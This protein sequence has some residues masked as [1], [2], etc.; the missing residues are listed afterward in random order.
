MPSTRE[1]NQSDPLIGLAPGRELNIDARQLVRADSERREVL[2]DRVRKACLG[3]GFFYVDNVFAGDSVAAN[4]LSQMQ[5][6]FSLPDDD[7]RK[8]AVDNRR[9]QGSYGWMPMFG[10][11]AY[12][13]G[14]RAHVESFD[15]GLGGN[16]YSMKA[17]EGSNVWPDLPGFRD[18]I[19]ALWDSLAALAGRVLEVLAEAASLERDF[20][21]SRC[22][23]QEFSTLRLLHYPGGP[24]EDRLRDVGIAAHTDFE[25]ISLILQ[26]GPGLELTDVRGQWYEAPAQPDR[27]IVLLDDML[28]RWTNGYFQAT[29]HRVRRTAASRYSI[30]L[31]VA[32]NA[33]QLIRPLDQF[34]SA[35][36]PARFDAVT[37]RQHIDTEVHRSEAYRAESLAAH[38]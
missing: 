4:A 8:I 29:G 10:E 23:T 35:T 13:P 20:L 27:V 26:T 34:V 25:C 9:K 18:D 11:P 5:R 2:V 17:L 1:L 30:V 15:C 32:V 36:N 28:E 21:S 3:T 19:G 7:P 16:A 12:Q 22:N 31:F 14:T 37:Q 38:R 24:S 33:D 6:F